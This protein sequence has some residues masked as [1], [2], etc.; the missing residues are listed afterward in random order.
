MEALVPN[1][2]RC[3]DN[4]AEPCIKRVCRFIALCPSILLRTSRFGSK[5]LV[6]NH[7]RNSGP[8]HT[9]TLVRAGARLARPHYA[10]KRAVKAVR[11][12]G[13][14]GL[15]KEAQKAARTQASHRKTA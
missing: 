12:K 13:K 9:Y 6:R 15:R 5:K 1:G 7:L 3:H 11:T 2:R 14:A 4:V 10:T 8:A